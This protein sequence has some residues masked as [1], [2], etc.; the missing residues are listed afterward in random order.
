MPPERVKLRLSD[1][2]NG[3]K[4][5]TLKFMIEHG[6]NIIPGGAIVIGLPATNM[7]YLNRL[8]DS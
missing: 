7:N 2:T 8:G 6:A 4:G 5:S 1:T 3:Y